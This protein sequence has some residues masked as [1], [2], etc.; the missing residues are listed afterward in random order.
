MHGFYKGGM[1]G[2]FIL[3]NKRHSWEQSALHAI[4]RLA[5]FSPMRLN[6]FRGIILLHANRVQRK[7]CDL[8]SDKLWSRHRR[9][10]WRR[11]IFRTKARNEESSL[12]RLWTTHCCCCFCYY[13]CPCGCVMSWMK[14]GSSNLFSMCSG[15]DIG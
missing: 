5:T 10:R 4:Q 12:C 9:H 8:D 6:C 7:I 1:C 13:S 11:L 15:C 3:I 14:C 2:C